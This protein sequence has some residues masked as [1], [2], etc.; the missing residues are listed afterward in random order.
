MRQR[1]KSVKGFP[2]AAW[3]MA[4]L[5]VASMTTPAFAKSKMAMPPALLQ[6]QDAFIAL[7]DDVKPAVVNIS[8]LTEET[9]DTKS[10][11]SQP[12]RQNPGTPPGTG[13]G[14]IFTETGY[15]MTNNHV[16]GDADE[17][18]V[19]LSDKR[20]FTGKVV[21][22]D[23]DTDVAVVKI[24]AKNKE[25]FPFVPIGDSSKL[26]VGQWVIAVGNPFGLDRT[27]TVGVVSGLGRE[28]VNLS[29]YEDYIQ[30]DASI[31]PGNS[32][33][34]LFNLSGEVVGINTAIL[35]FAQ[36]I[37]FAIP[38]NMAK[39]VADQLIAHGN[40]VRG[41]LGIGIQQLTPEL[42]EE[43]SV[44]ESDGVLVNE[45]F[46]GD[47]ADKAGLQPGDIITKVDGREV[48]TPSSLA[49]LIAEHPPGQNVKLDVLR[50]G[51]MLNYTIQLSERPQ[52]P[53]TVKATPPEAP[54]PHSEPV[55]GLMI[56]ELTPELADQYK[57]KVTSGIV[58]SKVIK[59]SPADNAGV[60]EGDL[61]LEVERT[62]V[63]TA[64]DFFES[65]THRSDENKLLL[66]IGREDRAFF[67]VIKPGETNPDSN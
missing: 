47:P 33:G 20:T 24:D 3:F 45:V 26:K 36:G 15:I 30:T 51:K 8:P 31:N 11:G 35:N 58:V 59:G 66:R 39:E 6:L 1:I 37:G 56:D 13:S 23:G 7:A 25:P 49:K 46:S 27:V 29:R 21:G 60:R 5:V 10:R 55:L 14:V 40:V 34:P 38:S 62:K 67:I 16:V 65:V 48:S 17:V 63:K 52:K 42:S 57:L 64:K 12:D 41:W 19:R 32:G 18:E 22:R 54:P 2:L 50:G 9:S 53:T 44:K 4:A 61:I 43:F 28:N